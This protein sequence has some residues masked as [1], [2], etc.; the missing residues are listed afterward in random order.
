MFDSMGSRQQQ[1]LKLLLENRAGLT[2][3]LIATDL[4]ISRNAVQQHFTSL[5]KAG[6]IQPGS[7]NKTAGRPVRNYIITEAGI[8]CFPK[9]YAWFSEIVLVALK[10]QLGSSGFAQFL[11]N[12]GENFAQSLIPQFTVKSSDGRVQQLVAIMQEL[13]YQAKYVQGKDQSIEACN[14]IYHDIAQKHSEVCQFDQ[15]LISTLLNKD[16]EISKCM[17]KGDNICCFKIKPNSVN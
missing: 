4:S 1:I 12:M 8:N 6:L 11:Q 13:G 7:L 17:A 9:Q 16:V 14:C 15:R 3:D 5:E 10:K 2:I